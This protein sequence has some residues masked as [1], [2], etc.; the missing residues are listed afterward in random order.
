MIVLALLVLLAGLAT[1]IVARRSAGARPPLAA[2]FPGQPSWVGTTP[3][4][5][6]RVWAAAALALT[7][8]TV[9]AL[10][11]IPIAGLVV[12]IFALTVL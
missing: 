7:I 9:G 3:P 2:H 1:G 12:A 6:L 10:L 11:V 8:G 4:M 5:R